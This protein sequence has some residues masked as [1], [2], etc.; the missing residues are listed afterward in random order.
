MRR[1]VSWET[2]IFWATGRQEKAPSF[3]SLATRNCCTAKSRP[4]GFARTDCR[5]SVTCPTTRLRTH[6]LSARDYAAH[7]CAP[8]AGRVRCCAVIARRSPVPAAMGKIHALSCRGLA[9]PAAARVFRSGSSRS[10]RRNRGP[11]CK[12][13]RRAKVM[14]GHKS[15]G[16][17][18]APLANPPKLV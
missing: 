5:H 13:G 14:R 12:R 8:W 3:Y 1:L 9:R 18:A 15:N 2:D 7:D 17:V 10:K 4:Q 16:F 11:S 6:L